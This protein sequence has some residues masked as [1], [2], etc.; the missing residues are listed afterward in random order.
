MESTSKC[1]LIANFEIVA[2]VLTL[3]VSILLLL[4]GR[5]FGLM[6]F[7]KVGEVI[8][9]SALIAA[10]LS[11]PTKRGVFQYG[12][13][14]LLLLPGIGMFMGT[15]EAPVWVIILYWTVLVIVSIISGV[16]AA[17]AYDNI[18]EVVSRRMLYRNSNVSLFEF[19]WR[20]T[21][22][23]FCSIAVSILVC[24]IWLLVMIVVAFGGFTS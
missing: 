22:D 2:Y 23:R 4:L 12:R 14:V 17:Y 6:D 10:L 16:I 9:Y 15:G 11:L 20:Y 19:T 7:E 13:Y 21:L 3:I 18:D 8:G 5:L 24:G 1:W